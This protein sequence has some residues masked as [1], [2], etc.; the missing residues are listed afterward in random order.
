MKLVDNI[1]K[2]FFFISGNGQLYW[3]NANVIWCNNSV[4][5]VVLRY[6]YAALLIIEIIYL[7][8]LLDIKI[9]IYTIMQ[10]LDRSRV[11]NSWSYN[12]L[13]IK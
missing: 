7:T 8:V 2:W 6:T 9:I 10:Q 13:N 4:L 12:S 5:R 11:R 1:S 3:F